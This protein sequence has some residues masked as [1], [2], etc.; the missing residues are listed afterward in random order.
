MWSP[1]LVLLCISCLVFAGGTD[2][3]PKQ[4]YRMATPTAENRRCHPRPLVAALHEPRFAD[5]LPGADGDHVDR[6]RAVRLADAMH[7]DLRRRGRALR[8]K[9]LATQ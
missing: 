3:F 8:V 7:R 1:Q 4:P 5:L 2:D 6:Q 9:D